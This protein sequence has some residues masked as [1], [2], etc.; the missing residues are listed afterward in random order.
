MEDKDYEGNTKWYGYM[1]NPELKYDPYHYERAK[2]AR[3][4]ILRIE[5]ENGAINV[6]EKGGEKHERVRLIVLPKKDGIDMQKNTR[7]TFRTFVKKINDRYHE[8]E[9]ALKQTPYV[10]H[11]EI[12]LPNTPNQHDPDD[13]W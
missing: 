1:I 2:N 4:Q 7:Q 8:V 6:I 10:D 5:N 9:N 13:K 11:N 12:P 3:M